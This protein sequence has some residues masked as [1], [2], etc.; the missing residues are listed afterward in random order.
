[1]NYKFYDQVIIR[2]PY[3]TFRT[4]FSK[5]DIKDQFSSKE[6]Q[7]ALFLASPDLYN[8]YKN[9]DVLNNT[10]GVKDKVANSLLKYLIRLHF[11]CTPFGLFA[12]CTCAPWQS[13]YILEKLNHER[14]TRLDMHF[15]CNLAQELAKREYIRPYLKFATNNSLY[16]LHDNYRY[17][18][19]FYRNN[20]RVYTLSSVESSPYLNKILKLADRA[21]VTISDIIESITDENVSADEVLSFVNEMIEGQ[22]LISE[23]EPSVIGDNHILQILNVLNLII[24]T[25]P[26]NQSLQETIL[27]LTDIQSK[28]KQLDNKFDNDVAEYQQLAEKISSLKVP[29]DQNKLFQTDLFKNVSQAAPVSDQLVTDVET[30]QSKLLIALKTLNKLTNTN[31]KNDLSEFQSKFSERFGDKEVSL[32]KALD[33]E[34]GIGYGRISNF[35]GETSPLLNDLNFPMANEASVEIKW[36]P[37]D[38]YLLKKLVNANKTDN[39]VVQLTLDEFAALPENWDDFPDSFSVVFSRI[40][41]TEGKEITIIKSVGGKSSVNLLGRFGSGNSAI[42][43]TIKAIA[44]HEASINPECILAEIV[45]LPESRVGNIMLRQ[46]SRD[47]EIPYLSSTPGRTDKQIPIND[48]YLSVRNNRF[49]LRSKKYNK[50]VMTYLDNAHNFTNGSLPVYHFLCDLQ[51]QQKRLGL[52]FSWGALGGEF[53]FL[54]RVELNNEIILSLAQWNLVKDNFEAL[55]SIKKNISDS[56]LISEFEKIRLLFK[57][58]RYFVLVE[59]DNELLID[60]ENQLSIRMFLQLI[61]K[62]TAIKLKEFIVFGENSIVKDINNQPF[63]NEFIAILLKD[64]KNSILKSV[65]KNDERQIIQ[66][67][68]FSIASE[69]LYYK[70]YCGTKVADQLLINYINRLTKKLI[71]QGLI[72]KWFF[73]RYMDPEF[74]LRIR[75]HLVDKVKIGEIAALISSYLSSYEKKSLIWKIQVDTYEREIER[76]NHHLIEDTESLFYH[77]SVF[78]LEWLSLIDLDNIE[79]ENLRWLFAIQSIDTLL[80][81]FKIDIPNKKA[82]LEN[83]KNGY[84]N[85]FKMDK[86]LKI[87]LDSKFRKHRSEISNFLKNGKKEPKYDKLFDFLDLRSSAQMTTIN[88]I[89]DKIKK[90][91]G[92]LQLLTFLPSY[93]HMNLNRIFKSNSRKQEFILYYL[94]DKYYGAEI[95]QRKDDK[96]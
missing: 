76:Y 61:E 22:L 56:N 72:D 9:W 96:F 17:I 6:L 25:T 8:E 50:E 13:N 84:G 88:S 40:V 82:L 75:F 43:E 11:R 34:T 92:K 39:Y 38:S 26:H 46:S 14:R 80:E 68:D 36:S 71:K 55:L 20:R 44:K 66:D 87:Q 16:K 60:S 78:N 12:G 81:D 29:F 23:L 83:L 74:H 5:A 30:L 3:K 41:N 77:D 67:R 53:K 27:I 79:G 58:P 64:A 49:R 65:V 21:G 42:A 24:S 2:T 31:R 32:M 57:L 47:F 59:G 18:E 1:M 63:N 33:N 94:M 70:I 93:I 62:K 7:E 52:A 69:W 45:H 15:T 91:K 90:S 54:P 48:L 37:L 95:A 28:L 35:T 51:S 73:I 19:Y 89:L 4:G 85:E 86:S 10:P